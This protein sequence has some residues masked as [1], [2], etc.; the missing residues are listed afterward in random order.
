[1]F[2]SCTSP[3]DGL[4]DVEGAVVVVENVSSEDAS[5]SE[6]AV[7]MS[8]SSSDGRKDVIPPESS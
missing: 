4:V 1:M 2:V 3:A 7:M 5:L 6:E 8:F